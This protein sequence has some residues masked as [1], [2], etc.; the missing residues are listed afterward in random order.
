[1]MRRAWWALAGVCYRV[2]EWAMAHV[3]EGVP[4]GETVERI[5]KGVLAELEVTDGAG[6]QRTGAGGANGSA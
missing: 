4:A 5:R 1:M 6:R 3:P 2:A